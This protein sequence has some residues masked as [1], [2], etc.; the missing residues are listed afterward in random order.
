MRSCQVSR[1]RRS[2]NANAL[3][4]TRTYQHPAYL[5]GH[6]GKVLRRDDLISVDVV[7]NHEALARVLLILF[8]ELWQLLQC[9]HTVIAT[10]ETSTRLFSAATRRM[11]RA[12]AP[13]TLGQPHS[14]PARA[15]FPATTT[16]R[17][18]HGTR[19]RALSSLR[20]RVFSRPWCSHT[21]FALLG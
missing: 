15:A 6:Q 5:G 17:Y 21:V 8:S 16:R 7:L 9:N 18:L 1:T 2:T 13:A 10:D 3:Q 4:R 14:L 12:L 11:R 19:R 20:K